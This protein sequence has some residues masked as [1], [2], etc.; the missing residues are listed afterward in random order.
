MSTE[1]GFA[2]ALVLWFIAGMSLLVAAIV[3]QARIDTQMAQLHLARAKA[4]AAG[5]GAI[6]LML[7]ELA[8]GVRHDIAG[9]G[10]LRGDYRLG[11]VAV[12]VQLYPAAGL[13][14]LN[15]ADER[16]L[17]ALFLEL[18]NLSAPDAAVLARD[19]LE[20][21]GLGNDGARATRP[22]KFQTPEDLLRIQGVQRSMFD[23]LRDYVVAGQLAAGR[24]DWSLAPDRLFTV[25]H[26]SDPARVANIS[27]R[28]EALSLPG[29][30][31]GGGPGASEGALRADAL[32]SYGGSTWLRRRWITPGESDTSGLPWRVV[33]TEAPRVYKGLM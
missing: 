17:S 19:V 16:L 9:P 32:V 3:S 11:D 13:V 33:R 14:D 4:V 12:T 23:A 10:R 8:G 30:Q 27:R 15:A 2:L 25:L 6:T 5:D 18:G 24:F 20:W 22:N 29:S 28:R 26:T 7:A 31:G 21:R 1:R